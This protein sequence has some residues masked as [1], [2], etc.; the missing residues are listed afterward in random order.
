MVWNLYREGPPGQFLPTGET[1][2]GTMDEVVTYMAALRDATG[3]CYGA[4]AAG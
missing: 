1:F 2:T 3:V 4:D